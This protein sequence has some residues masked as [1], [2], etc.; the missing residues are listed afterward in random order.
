LPGN[1]DRGASH[2]AIALLR[3]RAGDVT[4]AKQRLNRAMRLG[5]G[6]LRSQQLLQQALHSMAPLTADGGGGGGTEGGGAGDA[7]QGGG[8]GG[9]AAGGAVA[10]PA[11]ND[12]RGAETMLASTS[13]MCRNG[14]NVAGQVAALELLEQLFARMMAV[15]GGGGPGGTG[16]GAAAAAA[17]EPELARK[18]AQNSNYLEKKRGQLSERLAAAEGSSPAEHRAVLAWGLGS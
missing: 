6:R 13:T 17:A 4:S 12:Y 11:H 10:A 18:A 14:G 1:A 15:A 3:L 7:S 16:G 8:V 5:H 2:L 9:A